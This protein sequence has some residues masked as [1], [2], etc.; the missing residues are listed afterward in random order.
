MTLMISVTDE[1]FMS[2]A[3]H[4]ATKSNLQSRHGCIAVI[5]GKIVGR[6]HNTIRS[7]SQ[8]GFIRNTCSCHAEMD[9]LRKCLKQNITKKISLYIARVTINGE[10]ACSAPC[11]DC[12][13]KMKDFNIRTLIYINHDGEI[14]KRNFDDFHTTHISSGKRALLLKRVKCI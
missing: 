5:N 6:G 13:M 14:I 2:H 11:I 8:D 4:E 10:L 9:V 7:Q 3:A 12:F 1:T